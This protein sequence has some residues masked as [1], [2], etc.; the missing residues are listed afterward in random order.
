M[1]NS[2]ELVGPATLSTMKWRVSIC[3]LVCSVVP[4]NTRI[5][6]PLVNGNRARNLPQYVPRWYGS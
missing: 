6:E 3:A 1:V 5:L 2:P 4:R